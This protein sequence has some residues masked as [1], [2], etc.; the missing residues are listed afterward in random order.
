MVWFGMVEVCEGAPVAMGGWVNGN[1]LS[2][3]LDMTKAW[4]GHGRTRFRLAPARACA[5]H[6]QTTAQPIT[7]LG[8][9][10]KLE[11]NRTTPM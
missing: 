9:Q 6:G 4:Y 2:I 8:T 5:Q 11:P 7:L 1:T 10:T 3:S